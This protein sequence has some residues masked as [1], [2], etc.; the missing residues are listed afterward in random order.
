MEERLGSVNANETEPDDETVVRRD[1]LKRVGKA[2]ATAPAI[3]LLMAA[4][5]KPASAEDTNGSCG[6]GSS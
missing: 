4:N 2:T 3:A 6:S 5:A 1:F